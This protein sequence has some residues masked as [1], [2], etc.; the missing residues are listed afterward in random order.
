[1]RVFG[2][3]FGKRVKELE[4]EITGLRREIQ[5]KDAELAHLEE[6]HGRLQRDQERLRQER[7]RLKQEL[8]TA[9]RARKRQ[10]APFSKGQPTSAPKRPGRKGG[11][12]YGP[13]RR[14]K[15]PAQVDQEVDAPLPA[16][17]PTCHGA[18]A[19]DRVEVLTFT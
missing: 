9:R 5:Q 16:G 19:H 10:A 7:D 2:L 18:L 4:T 13:K 3:T 6:R 8:A 12:Q 14:R 17:C 1:M 15:I 11:P